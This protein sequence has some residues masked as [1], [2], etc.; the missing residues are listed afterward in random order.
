MPILLTL[1]VLL[2][3]TEI[4][5]LL[6]PKNK[7]NYLFKHL[8][9]F[10]VNVWYPSGMLELI[11]PKAVKKYWGVDSISTLGVYPI[12]YRPTRWINTVLT[13]CIFRR[14]YITGVRH[15]VRFRYSASFLLKVCFLS[16]LLTNLER[17]SLYCLTG[18]DKRR[19]YVQVSPNNFYI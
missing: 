4:L 13:V 19:V 1:C 12:N 6:L 7:G 16:P 8:Q 9:V 11:L 15:D 10:W 18:L 5:C 2:W 17:S 3:Y 14:K